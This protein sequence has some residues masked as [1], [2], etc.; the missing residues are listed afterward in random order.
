MGFWSGRRGVGDARGEVA[1]VTE[2]EV[3]IGTRARI[4]E[5]T[6]F[7][8]GDEFASEAQVREYF[9]PENIEF[10]FGDCPLSRAELDAMAEAVLRYRWHCS[11]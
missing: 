11:F 6:A 9:T 10:M 2:E 5:A 3:L 4:S 8:A 7:D 1:T